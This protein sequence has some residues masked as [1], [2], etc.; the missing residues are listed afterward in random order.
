MLDTITGD[1]KGRKKLELPCDKEVMKQAM[2][3]LAYLRERQTQRLHSPNTTAP[4]RSSKI[5]MDA[6]KRY[7]QQL[8]WGQLKSKYSSSC[9]IRQAYTPRDH[10]R[11]FL[12]QWWLLGN[13]PQLRAMREHFA[14]AVRHSMILRDEDLRYL[15][16]SDCSMKQIPNQFGGSQAVLMLVFSMKGDTIN[17]KKKQQYTV[18]I[19]HREVLRCSVG[20]LAFYFFDRWKVIGR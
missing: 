8:V 13:T 17:Q 6:L 15:N 2:K 4:L 11:M 19:R 3:A 5:L 10:T 7:R 1:A 20:A 18:A 16:Q 12:D 9:I 14:L